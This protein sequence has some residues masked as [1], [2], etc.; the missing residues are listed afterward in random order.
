MHD[1]FFFPNLSMGKW[2]LY[3]TLAAWV[4]KMLL[5]L[6]FILYSQ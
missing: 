2:K 5:I 6:I 4:V 1:W 3:K